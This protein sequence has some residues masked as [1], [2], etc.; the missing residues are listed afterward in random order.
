MLYSTLL[1]KTKK[2]APKDEV[3]K[4][5][6]LLI[7]AG[8]V[9]KEMAGVYA[10]LPLGLLV[11]EKIKQIV[12][13]EMDAIGGQELIMT[14]MQRKE[15]WEKTNRWDDEKVDVW[16]KTKLKNETEIGLAWSHEEPISDMM[17]QYIKSYKDLPLYVYQFQTKLRN[18]LRAKSGIMRGREFFMK[19]M[20]SYTL[21]QKHHDEFYNKAI[22]AYMKV[23][24][25]VG[26]RNE[27]Y[28]T[29]ASG[30]AFT[31]FSHEFQTLT[32]AG[33]DTVYF[34][35]EKGLAI[36]QEV[37]N[38]ETLA[39]LGVKKEDLTQANAAEVGNIFD[40][41]AVK[42]EQLGLNYTDQD[43]KSI[44]VH[45][46]SYGIGI[47]RLMGVIVE[48]LSDAKG[49]VWPESIA[50]YQVHLVGLNL[51]DSEVKKQSQ[52]V[53]AE[54]LNQNIEVLFDD[55]EDVTAGEKFSDADLIG[56][57]YRA[58]ISKKT[59]DKVELKKRTGETS[60]IVDIDSL[61]KLL[62]SN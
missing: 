8:F 37:Y 16:F 32:D 13:E 25:R 27:T 48:K 2:E 24:D 40:F 38:D 59:G 43:G 60:K 19:D 23:F 17:R 29:F 42:S 28:L 45:L 47:T 39:K 21:D 46:G 6:Q 57:P 55:R 33:E 30:S 26:L 10:Y 56:I 36:N 12:R 11:I 35:K 9:Y 18:E 7:R 22:E 50:P 31:K 4:N 44:P 3:S 20:Y 62:K 5:A 53:Y 49:I 15:L 14:C 52:G 1:G 58:V 34:S 61:L 41:G 51:E 54:L